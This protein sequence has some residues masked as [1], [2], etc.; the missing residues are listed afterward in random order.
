M[1][2]VVKA[3]PKQHGAIRRKML[4]GKD[5][6]SYTSDMA[7]VNPV[8]HDVPHARVEAHARK[9]AAASRKP[10]AVQ[11]SHPESGLLL[12]NLI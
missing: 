7:Q 6:I 4:L 3:N 8:L 2:T 9:A 11:L 1:G 10:R 12:R 5:C